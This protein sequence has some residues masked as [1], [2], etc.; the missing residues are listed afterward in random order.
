MRKILLFV[1]LIGVVEVYAQ[2]KP[3]VILCKYA[4]TTGYHDAMYTLYTWWPQ[5]IRSD[6]RLRLTTISEEYLNAIK[7]AL[8]RAVI[9]E[10][11][12][13]PSW[14][15][16]TYFLWVRYNGRKIYMAINITDFDYFEFMYNCAE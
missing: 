9:N 6:G 1:L 16:A 4:G 11:W 12:Q 10:G 3:E 13:G 14:L 2:S 5:S 15:G 8:E 7:P